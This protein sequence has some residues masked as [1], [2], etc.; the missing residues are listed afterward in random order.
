MIRAPALI[1]RGLGHLERVVPPLPALL[2]AARIWAAIVLALYAAF[3]LQLGSAA[4]AA[5]CVAILAQ[6]QAGQALSKALYRFVGTLVG[7]AVAVALVALFGQDRVLMLVSF[8]VWLALCVF[9]AQYL[10]DSRAYAALLAGYTVAIIALAGI[11]A[12]QTAFETTVDRVAAIVLG[13]AA[14]AFV[15]DVLGAPT[16]RAALERS[17]GE[18]AAGV[19]RLCADLLAEDRP[20]LDRIAATV[21]RIGAL[22]SDAAALAAERGGRHRAA[23]ARSAIAALYTQ[24]SS[25]LALVETGPVAG[26]PADEARRLCAEIAAGPGPERLAA[27]A[28]RLRRLVDDAVAGDRPVGD[29]AAVQRAL[30]LANA[31]WFAADGRRAL[32][33][34]APPLRDPPLPVHRDFPEAL[35]AAARVALAF[36][37]TAAFLVAAG[38][39]QAAGA[40]TQVSA[41]CAL[42]SVAPDPGRFA[43]SVLTALPVAALLAG[44]TLFAV[45]LE[46]DA[47]PVLAL[48]LAPTVLLCGLMTLTPAVGA[49]GSVALILTLMFL[50]PA[51]PQ[52]F[53]ADALF[54]NLLVTG[55]CCLILALTIRLVLPVTAGRHRAFAVAE[56][57]RDLAAAL[58]GSGGDATA[59][60]SLNADRLVQFARWTTGCAA[61]RRAS[62]R[63]AVALS[64]LESSAARAHEQ[65]RLLAPVEDLGDPVRG[66]RAALT[67]HD[68]PAL[69]AAAADL[70]RHGRAAEPAPRAPRAPG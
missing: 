21:A 43:R 20:D 34:G 35:R 17:L 49:T 69:E 33:T 14:V 60:L 47:F 53:D 11:D 28:D 23:G 55:A 27:I 66:A 16:V 67:R 36:A 7:G 9:V 42:S 41:M 10:R 3:W 12:P 48:L 54:M 59:R 8:T 38:L 52:R 68:A 24:L 40:L 18:A 63:H 25:C 19:N 46:A 39:P 44:L 31:A 4:S 1:D 61:A 56:A 6:P 62:L 13:I 50:V 26:A 51:N 45:P 64:C 32:A 37:A 22:R 57:R 5:V 30:D 58:A 65:L 15:N 29:V 2:Y 70:L